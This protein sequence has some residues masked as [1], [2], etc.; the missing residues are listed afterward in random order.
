MKND[1]YI[2]WD[3]ETTGF[4]P[5]HD[6]I[7]E[8]GM[9][10]V[11]GDKVERKAWLL[12]HDIEIPEKITELTTITKELLDKDGEN[13]AECLE[14]FIKEIMV[15]ETNVTHNGIAFDIP[16]ILGAVKK[17]LHYTADQ[18]AELRAHLLMTAIDTCILIKGRKLKIGMEP[19]EK[20][21]HYANRVKDIRAKGVKSNLTTVCEEMEIKINES[22]R[23]RA[24]GDVELT[25]QVYIKTL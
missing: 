25:N 15:A 16:F 4:R 7:I 3:L 6:A 8:I 11:D 21:R 17:H 22:N 12:N 13:P 14:A 9:M 23:H 5:E 18:E 10:I 19:G 24:L 2:V 20:F 1:K